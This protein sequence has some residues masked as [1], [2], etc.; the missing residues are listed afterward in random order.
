MKISDLPL[1]AAPTGD[2]TVVAVQDGDTVKASMNA[3]LAPALATAQDA[4]DAAVAAQQSVADQVAAISP[5][6]ATVA[7]AAGDIATTVANLPA[8]LDAPA[9][10]ANAA[11]SAAAAGSAITIYG[12][13]APDAVTGGVDGNDYVDTT[14]QRRYG[15]RAAGVWPTRFVEPRNVGLFE[16]CTVVFMMGQSNA[17]GWSTDP[18]NTTAMTLGYGYEY[19][20]D[21]GGFG[22]VLP[23]GKNRLGRTQGGPQCAFAQTW[24]AGGG[25]PCIFVDCAVGGSSMLSAYKTTLTGAPNVPNL[26]GGTWD[27][28]DADN[29][30][31]R[32]IRDHMR[33]ALEEI[34]RLGFRVRKQV[35]YWSQGEQDAL[36]SSSQAAHEAP[37]GAFL[38][39]LKLDFPD[40]WF[41][42]ENLGEN[43]TGGPTPGAA[44][45]RAAQVAVAALP[46]FSPWVK[47]CSTLAVGFG[48]SDYADTLHYNQNAYNSL[49]SQMAS[50]GLTFTKS[51]GLLAVPGTAKVNDILAN[52][53]PVGGWY[54]MRVQTSANGAW[55]IQLYSDPTTPYG[56]TWYDGSGALGV[57]G[58]DAAQ[59]VSWSWPNGN[60]KWVWLYVHVSTGASL[61][62]VGQSN[63]ALTDMQ[64]IDEGFPLNTVN[65]GSSGAMANGFN[66]S[67]ADIYRF[68][69]TTLR[70]L[71]IS[72]SS[73]SFGGSTFTSTLLSKLTGLTAIRVGRTPTV[74]N[75]DL[76]LTPNL[77]TFTQN[78][79]GLSVSQVNTILTQL[80]ANGK[81]NGNVQVNQYLAS[82]YAASPP[83]GAGATAKTNLQAKGW[84]VTTD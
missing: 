28:A 38:R 72:A 41:L 19:Y 45:V 7:G 51:S 26:S 62:L 73:P 17:D 23:L 56:G 70:D 15:P 81:S 66:L 14:T 82:F 47:I 12:L 43:S 78:A 30:Y 2:E 29:L 46:E 37:L 40:T 24:A 36:G 21:R 22:T 74:V 64:V 34:R 11:A 79:S 27:Q 63:S 25:G 58:A 31:T 4:A 3:L 32:F 48:P 59:I 55:G 75:L 71:G 8:I 84:T 39:R 69:N 54:R 16:D 57:T 50:Q 20:H 1:A 77:V 76:T 13:G 42:I 61:N 35:V 18:Q 44:N 65:F 9:Q 80:D 5:D 6:L 60:S 53:P 83:S 52:M 68:S 33:F 49:G 10:A 67:N